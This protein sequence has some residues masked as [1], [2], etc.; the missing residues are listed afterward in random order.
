MEIKDLYNH[1]QEYKLNDFLIDS[2]QLKNAGQTIFFAIKTDTGN[3][4]LYI[5]DLYEKGVRHF[6][7]E[8][9]IFLEYKEEI[10]IFKVKN[11][12]QCLQDIAKYHRQFYQYPVFGI[13]GSNGKTIVK[14]WLFQLLNLDFNI[15]RS[16]QSF[17]S[18]IGVPLSVLQMTNEHNLGIFE[19]GISQKGEMKTIAPIID[20]NLGV[21]TSI[22]TAHES[23]FKSEKEKILEKLHLFQNAKCLI[24]PKS[25]R[26]I[27]DWLKQHPESKGVSWSMSEEADLVIQEIEER[28]KGSFIHLQYKNEKWG[29]AIPFKD[30]VSCNNAIICCLTLL[31][32]G[33]AKEKIIQRMISLQSVAMR[34]ELKEGIKG[35]VLINDTYNLDWNS[36]ISGLR[37]LK[38]QAGNKKK[39][40]ILSDILEHQDHNEA[41]YQKLSELL[42]KEFEIDQIIGVGNDIMY[43]NNYINNKNIKRFFYKSTDL[44]IANLDEIDID[45]HIILIKGARKFQ[46][47]RVVQNLERQVHRTYLEINLNAFKHNFN[48]FKNKLDNDTKIMVMVKASAYGSGS[49]RIAQLMEQLGADYLAVAYIDEGIALRNAGVQLPILVLNPDEEGFEAM[50]KFK[51]EPEIYSLIQLKKY[52]QYCQSNFTK[53]LIHINIDTGMKRLGFEAHEIDELAYF[54]KTHKI[55]VQSIFS[56]LVASDDDAYDEFSQ[57]QINHFLAMYEQLKPSC[58]NKPLLHILNSSGILRFPNYQLDM[59]RL[60]I[61]LYGISTPQFRNELKN[62]S[63]LKASISQIK[64]LKKGETVGY[65]RTGLAHKDLKIATVNIGYADGIARACGNG[66]YSFVLRGKKVKTIGTISMDMCMIDITEV[67]DCRVGDEVIIFGKDLSIYELAKCMNTIPYEVLTSIS[68]RV[69]RVY[70]L[71]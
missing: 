66:N 14:E 6:V 3:G 67:S 30:E 64:Y 21:F 63:T 16:P 71:D 70:I 25:I 46:F 7:I 48:Y 22:G 69:K 50:V 36:L 13:T 52:Y 60:G 35:T 19:A 28:E 54:I 58:I 44:L 53:C 10:F 2:R 42:I 39:I 31:E 17:N 12:I 57:Q 20:C 33:I 59:V 18:Q 38:N 26:V 4:H 9:E 62:I 65:N 41:L 56:H 15:V 29:F 51:L 37:L 32:L 27:D 45:N 34:L 24:Y 11:A 23:G 55:Y 1:I 49:I 47:E 61:G 40:L 8:E 43:L 68:D 5:N